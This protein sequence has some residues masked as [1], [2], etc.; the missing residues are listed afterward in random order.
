MKSPLQKEGGAET[1]LSGCQ[2][3]LWR[4]WRESS[5][6][7]KGEAARKAEW[8][9]DQEV[10]LRRVTERRA[11]R[12]GEGRRQGRVKECL[13]RR[14]ESSSTLRMPRERC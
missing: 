13:L 5:Q 4:S 3:L 12:M 14:E 6:E 2:V 10:F 11:G 9:E 7:G 8:K 1:S